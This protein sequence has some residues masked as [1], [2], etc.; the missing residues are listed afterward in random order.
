[1]VHVPLSLWRRSS[2]AE[3]ESSQHTNDLCGTQT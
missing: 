1:M 2:G 3:Q